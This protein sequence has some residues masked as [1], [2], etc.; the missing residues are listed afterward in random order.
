MIYQGSKKYPVEE[1]VLHCSATMPSWMKDKPF[2]DQV[3]EITRWHVEDRG[4]KTIGYHWIISR[5]GD[6]LPGRPE[7]VI[8]AGVLGHNSGV[9]HV[10]LIGGGGSSADD[11]FGDNFTDAQAAAVKAKIADIKSR[12]TIRKITGHNEYAAKACPGF[13]VE[14]WMLSWGA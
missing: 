12:T 9:I 6:V 4:W 5:E 11:Q 2:K 7:T 3:A 1:I 14:K 10:C 13:R 8:G